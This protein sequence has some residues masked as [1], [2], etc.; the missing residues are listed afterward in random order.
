MFGAVTFNS[1]TGW[2]LYLNDNPVVTNG[3]TDQFSSNPAL[4]E[5]GAF[6][7]STNLNG[8]VAVSLIYNRALSEAEIAQNF[9]HYQS[10]FGL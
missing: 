9:A 8:D 7:N 6:N 3:S 1:S 10:R 5:I 4:V 2:K